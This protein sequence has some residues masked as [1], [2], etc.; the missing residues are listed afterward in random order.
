MSVLQIGSAFS[1]FWS[2][3]SRGVKAPRRCRRQCKATLRVAVCFFRCW[4]CLAN[5][6]SRDVCVRALQK[7]RFCSSEVPSAGVPRPRDDADGS[8][9]PHCGSL[10][11]SFAVGGVWRIFLAVM[12]A[13]VRCKNVGFAGRKCPQQGCQGPETMQT[14]V[15][16]HIAGRCVFLS[17]LVVSG[18]F[19]WP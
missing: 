15:Q 14:A 1:A 12:F 3:N 10:C 11:V 8:A 17:L 19:S 18:E 2:P 5:F 4:W 16:S 6:L 9:K 7:C 13:C